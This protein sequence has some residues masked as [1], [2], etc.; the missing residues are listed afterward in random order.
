M[1]DYRCLSTAVNRQSRDLWC[2]R[3]LVG[4]TPNDTAEEKEEIHYKGGGIPPA[5]WDNQIETAD[6]DNIDK[7]AAEGR[8]GRGSRDRMTAETGETVGSNLCCK[9]QPWN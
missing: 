1:A 9:G 6:I 4:D 2:C 5:A 7:Q 8:R 3:C